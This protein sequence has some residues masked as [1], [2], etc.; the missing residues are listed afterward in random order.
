MRSAQLPHP[1][2]VSCSDLFAHGKY[3]QE[4]RRRGICGRNLL[5]HKLYSH[6]TCIIFPVCGKCGTN[7]RNGSKIV[8]G[9]AAWPGEVPWQV[10]LESRFWPDY[11]DPV[12]HTLGPKFFCGGTLINANWVLTARHCTRG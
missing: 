7:S 10:G 9:T 1:S 5:P 11:I 3:T 4:K 2:R 6:G 8:L 12:Y